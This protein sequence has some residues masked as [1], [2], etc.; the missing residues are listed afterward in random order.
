MAEGSICGHG[1]P[2][3]GC[4]SGWCLLDGGHSGPHT[5]QQERCLCGA[6]Y[7]GTR[8][9]FIRTGDERYLKSMLQLVLEADGGP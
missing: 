7:E 9:A 5:G 3:S 4:G 8:E 2:G 1:Y 6:T